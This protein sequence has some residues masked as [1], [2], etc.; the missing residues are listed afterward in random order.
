LWWDAG[1]AWFI[2]LGK[3]EGDR[4]NF[5]SGE[6]ETKVLEP[7]L[8]VRFA[9]DMRVDTVCDYGADTKGIVR[10]DAGERG[11]I[12]GFETNRA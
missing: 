9:E 7:A 5:E 12:G 4:D 2:G 10:S 1:D 8:Y 3:A 6:I 11:G